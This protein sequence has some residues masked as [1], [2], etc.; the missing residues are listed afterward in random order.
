M[1]ALFD[2]PTVLHHDDL[3]GGSGRS[4]AMGNVQGSRTSSGADVTDNAIDSALSQSV[5]GRRRFVQHQ[6]LGLSSEASGQSQPLPLSFRQIRTARFELA[7]RGVGAQWKR[8]HLLRQ[9]CLLKQ[10]R[11]LRIGKTRI[12]QLQLFSRRQLILAI[13]LINN[14]EIRLYLSGGKRPDISTVQQNPAAVV[15]VEPGE[16]LDDRG[17]PAPV[18]ADERVLLPWVDGETEVMKSESCHDRVWINCEKAMIKLI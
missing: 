15:I 3:I 16:E 17:L 7:Q 6:E 18:L 9:T 4:Q 13:V 11:D 2:N 14:S 12:A 10:G 5:K 8:S 1:C